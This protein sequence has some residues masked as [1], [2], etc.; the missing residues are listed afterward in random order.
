MPK[1]KIQI[2]TSG[3]Y[4]P[5]WQSRF[6]P[7]NLPKT[8]WLT[9]YATHFSCVEL[10][11]SFYRLP[12]KETI[13]QWVEQT[14]ADFVFAVKAN[15][16]ITHMKK[17]RNCK[18][19]LDRFVDTIACFENKLGPV[20]FQ[21]PPHW[22]INADRLEIFLEMLPRN[23]GYAFEFRDATWYDEK[24][25]RLLLK[26]RIA[27]CLFDLA[28]FRSPEALTSDIIYIRLH[29]PDDAYCGSYSIESLK[30]WAQKIINW[31]AENRLVYLFF[32]NDQNGY[33]AENTR[34]I[35][36]LCSEL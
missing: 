4:Y 3:W 23:L 36:H 25:Y 28:H 14:P 24:I 26:Y 6:Y 22:H 11:N 10:N 31:N 5:H 21:L 18:D 17:L 33:A 9:W 12:R 32:D 29:G 16:L 27:F 19:T 30:E 20:L 13:R 7:D 35:R 8:K 34:M 2:G 1:Y 15:R